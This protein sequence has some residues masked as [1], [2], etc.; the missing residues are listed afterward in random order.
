MGFAG[1]LLIGRDGASARLNLHGVTGVLTGI[2]MLATGAVANWLA[3]ASSRNKP[4]NR[5]LVIRR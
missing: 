4:R 1:C 5:K 3:S 2:Y